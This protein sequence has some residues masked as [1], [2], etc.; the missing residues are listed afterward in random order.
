MLAQPLRL[1][2]AQRAQPVVLGLVPGLGVGLAVADQGDL[3]HRGAP[4]WFAL[5]IFQRR[6]RGK[7]GRLRRGYFS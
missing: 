5:L 7:G 2:V 6:A 1:L 4:L 3:G